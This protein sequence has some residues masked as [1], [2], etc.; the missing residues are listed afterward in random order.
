MM[1][2][3]QR[4]TGTTYVV[5]AYRF[6]SAEVELFGGGYEGP[7]RGGGRRG[8]QTMWE[9]NVNTPG[10]NPVR[11]LAHE[12]GGAESRA[13]G[14]RHDGPSVAA[15]NNYRRIHRGCGQRRDHKDNHA[16]DCP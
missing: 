6:N 1:L 8:D 7:D 9:V 14:G 16:G 13:H 3:M 10:R 2:R 4:D 15:E 12:L 11:T 5:R